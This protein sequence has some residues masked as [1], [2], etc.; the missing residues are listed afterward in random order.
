VDVVMRVDVG[1]S[2][3]DEAFER[4]QLTCERALDVS[5]VV[6]EVKADRKRRMVAGG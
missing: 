2:P 5:A 3:S 1:R 6:D 4:I